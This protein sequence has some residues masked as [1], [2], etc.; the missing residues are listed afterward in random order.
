MADGV[1]YKKMTRKAD[2][3]LQGKIVA[4]YSKQEKQSY[5]IQ[6]M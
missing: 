3:G 1:V 6:K 2:Q 5:S 4:K